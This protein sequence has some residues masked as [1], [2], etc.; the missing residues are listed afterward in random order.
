VTQTPAVDSSTY[1]GNGSRK[2]KM[3]MARPVK[4]AMEGRAL[5]HGGLPSIVT[6]LLLVRR[7][8]RAARECGRMFR[9]D[10][11]TS[12]FA[13]KSPDMRGRV[14]T[15]RRVTLILRQHFLAPILRNK[16]SKDHDS[17]HGCTYPSRLCI[18]KKKAVDNASRP[19]GVKCRRVYGMYSIGVGRTVA[20]GGLWRGQSEKAVC[21]I[22]PTLASV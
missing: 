13:G 14:R 20:E 5:V 18:G 2:C 16:S 22:W 1:D 17:G 10:G 7:A 12:Q 21:R 11:K 8:I 3:A 15:V 6:V 9:T 19:P 4:A